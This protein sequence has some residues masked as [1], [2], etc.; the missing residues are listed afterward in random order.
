MS[1]LCRHLC[2]S[3]LLADPAVQHQAPT[4]PSAGS[5]QGRDLCGQ[6]EGLGQ[7]EI[8]KMWGFKLL[9][10]FMSS[11]GFTATE[12]AVK[13]FTQWVQSPGALPSSMGMGWVWGSASP[14]AGLQK[15]FLSFNPP[16]KP[17]S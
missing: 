2:P 17:S 15:I 14:M 1:G 6:A 11:R 16:H 13:P 12:L 9:N 4:A 3:W 5:S 10:R 8:S 7:V